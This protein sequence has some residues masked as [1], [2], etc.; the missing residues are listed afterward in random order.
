M[1]GSHSARKLNIVKVSCSPVSDHINGLY[2][3]RGR[4]FDDRLESSENDESQENPSSPYLKLH[5]T[6]IAGANTTLPTAL[7]A[8]FCITTSPF[9]RST[10]FSRR[11]IAVGGLNSSRIVNAWGEEIC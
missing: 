1:E 4:D 5:A 8:P 9:F 7:L 3:S 2:A 11:Q 10:N 6:Y